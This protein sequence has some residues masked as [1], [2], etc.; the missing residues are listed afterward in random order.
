MAVMVSVAALLGGLNSPAGS[1]VGPQ[2]IVAAHSGKVMDV[3]NASTAG[4]VPIVQWT[5]HDMANQ[6]WHLKRFSVVN[7]FNL[8][9]IQSANTNRV[10]DVAQGSTANGVGLVQN[11][12]A[13]TESQL[14][15]VY[16]FGATG[17]NLLF[18]VKSGKVADV[19]LGSEANGAIIVQFDWH[20]G[21]NQ[22]WQTPDVEI[23]VIPTT[24]ATVAPTTTTTAPTTTTT[25][26][27]TTTTEA[28]TTTTEPAEA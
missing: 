15:L 19:A 9:L 21:L 4:G 11:P 14:W 18:N 5:S 13:A 3:F 20:G 16:P 7:G 24:T 25:A 17:Y 1:V 22:I 6:E 12:W 8:V 28:T 23:P 26:P 10:I 27:T 2:H